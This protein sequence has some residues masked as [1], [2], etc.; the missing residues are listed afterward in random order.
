MRFLSSDV[1]RATLDDL[2]QLMDLWK[3]EKL[4]AE[5]LERR[6]TEFQLVT[7]AHG[8]IIGAVGMQIKD[9]QGK[10]HS[11]LFPAYEHADELRPLFWERMQMVAK[12]HGITR[13]W[14]QLSAPFWQMGD[15][16]DASEEELAL[17]PTQFVGQHVP[18]MTM[19]LREDS[20]PLVAAEKELAMFREL[21]RAGSER[22]LRQARVFKFIAATLAF[23]VLIWIAYWLI[24]IF[25]KTGFGPLGG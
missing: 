24:Q 25:R 22:I 11:E 10:L 4:P 2:P 14:T 6:F 23:G 17:L 12:N 13:V 9:K 21:E 7:D 1:R 16:H 19:L 5:V 20:A 15:F 3:L 8:K 18:W